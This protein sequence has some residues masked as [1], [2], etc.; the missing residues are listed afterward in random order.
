M[1]CRPAL[2][3]E[4][5]TPEPLI[6]ILPKTYFA[7][8]EAGDHT[9]VAYHTHRLL[10]RLGQLTARDQCGQAREVAGHDAILVHGR[11]D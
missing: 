5:Q 1:S 10:E 6:F 7:E 9:A 4:S 11:R 8:R 3:G 2:Q